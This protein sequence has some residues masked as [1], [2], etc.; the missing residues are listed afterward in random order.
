MLNDRRVHLSWGPE[1]RRSCPPTQ[2]VNINKRQS[3]NAV[4]ELQTQEE[5]NLPSEDL[6]MEQLQVRRNLAADVVVNVGA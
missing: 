6:V 2:T 3:R 5:S 1:T 4:D